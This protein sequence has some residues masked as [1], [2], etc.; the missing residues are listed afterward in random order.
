MIR[1][2]VLSRTREAL[3]EFV[4]RVSKR[5]ATAE[6]LEALPEVARALVESLKID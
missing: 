4:E 5:G 3:L 2:E 6:E 1:W